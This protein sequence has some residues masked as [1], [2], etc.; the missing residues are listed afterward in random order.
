MVVK[1]SNKL[2]LGGFIGIIL[3]FIIFMAVLTA[4]VPKIK[5][6]TVG[7]E[8][9]ES[10]ES[11]SLLEEDSASFGGINTNGTWNITVRYSDKQEVLFEGSKE[12]LSKITV[13]VRNNVLYLKG[14]KETNP[15]EIMYTVTINTPELSDLDCHGVAN[16]DIDGL[17]S[18]NFNI[19]GDGVFSLITSNSKYRSVKL[20]I[21]GIGNIELKDSET[22]ELYIDSSI[23]GNIEIDAN[24]VAVE[25]TIEGMGA[26]TI[27]GGVKSNSLKKDGLVEVIVN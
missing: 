13:S 17:D 23:V 8:R 19:N 5:P 22:E 14:P 9:L 10:Y 4:K 6:G 15:E 2:L 21:D 12:L 16:I 26:L 27:N 24:N 25:G 20:F 3:F 11:H 18:E 7:Y 1:L